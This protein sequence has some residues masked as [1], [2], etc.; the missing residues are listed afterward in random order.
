MVEQNNGSAI[1]L[2]I[3]HISGW[4]HSLRRA[5]GDRSRLCKV[6]RDKSDR[7]VPGGSA[8]CPPR[9]AGLIRRDVVCHPASNRVDRWNVGSIQRVPN[10]V[11]DNKRLTLRWSNLALARQCLAAE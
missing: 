2:C 1:A 9:Y 5:G 10:D 11:V 7:D 3:C 6:G 4:L 8:A